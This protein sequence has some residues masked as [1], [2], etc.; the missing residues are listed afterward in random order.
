VTLVQRLAEQQKSASLKQLASRISAVMK[1]GLKGGDDAA[2]PFVKI[3]GMLSEMIKKLSREQR[4]DGTEQEYCNKEMKKTKANREELTD[5]SE[6]L[7]AKI[8]QA[9]AAS[10]KLKS[11]VKDLQYELLTL[12]KLTKEMSSARNDAHKVFETDKD[13]LSQGLNA[14]RSAIHVLRDYYAQDKEDESLLQTQ[15]ATEDSD[16]DSES[17]GDS[18]VMSQPKPPQK[19]EKSGGAGQ[20]IIGTLEV[21]ESDLAK[22]MAE[23]Q[24]EEDD[25]QTAY[26]KE[27]QQGKVSKAEKDQDVTYNIREY[28]SLDKSVADLSSDLASTNEELAAVNEYFAKVKDRCVAKPDKYEDRKARREQ[29]IKGLEEAKS[30]ILSEGAF[31][32]R[33]V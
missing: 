18:D 6:G 32:Q 15:T 29:Q 19:F 14:I 22:N 1:Y 13:D 24:T 2:D 31:L 16:S 27:V 26:Q 20:G 33:R 7:K 3:K 8:D 28:T 17:D 11:Q 23:L 30:I 9:A 5:D 25:A 10:T 4:S 21:V 12:E